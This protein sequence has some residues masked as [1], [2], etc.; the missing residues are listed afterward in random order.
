MNQFVKILI[1][2]FFF[3]GYVSN[4]F[5]QKPFQ[6][7]R[8]ENYDLKVQV[9]ATRIVKITSKTASLFVSVHFSEFDLPLGD[10][11]VVRTL[12]SSTELQY[13]GLGEGNKG[14]TGGF[15]T[16]TLRGNA[17]IV[18]YFSVQKSNDR[19]AFSIDK[20]FYSV[21][22]ASP[23]KACGADDSRPAKCYLDNRTKE[24]FF[25]KTARAV[26]R[27]Q[28]PNIGGACTGWLVGSEGHLI[29]NHHC[30]STPEDAK[31]VQVEFMAE[32]SSCEEECK[33]LLGCP[34]ET[35]SGGATIIAT[36]KKHDY[37]LVKLNTTK[38][39]AEYGYLKLRATG[40][41]LGEE[42]YIPQHPRGY[43]KRI[44]VKVDDGTPVRVEFVNQ[45]GVC[46]KNRVGY[47][48]DTEIGSSGSPVISVA[49]NTVIALHSCGVTSPFCQ[50]SGVDIRD[51]IESLIAL[52]V[53][54]HDSLING[55]VLSLPPIAKT[56]PPAAQTTLAPTPTND[57]CFIFRQQKSCE[58]VTNLCEWLDG[59]CLRKVRK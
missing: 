59:K 23:D 44:A 31:N 54:P 45:N 35:L 14:K 19:V 29:T 5:A 41:I 17:V 3:L 20:Y 34:G 2:T 21:N 1:L 47:Y 37:T 12:D 58:T 7:G 32:S 36:N 30:I 15:W 18:E 52:D 46:G 10:R 53:L 25:Y 27:L 51:V 48:A 9:G 13:V 38:S 8:S 24:N 43:A 33:I 57:L 40:P 55:S 16:P 6:V 42:I 39:L 11:V 26:V 28:L 4:V 22:R 56:T 50:N 49:D